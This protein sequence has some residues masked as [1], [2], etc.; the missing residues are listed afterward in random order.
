M[1][2]EL[3]ANCRTQA[4]AEYDDTTDPQEYLSC[5]ENA[6]LLHRYTNEIKCRVFVITFTH[7][8]QQWFNQLPVGAIGSFQEFRSL[9]L[10][11]FASSQKLQKMELSL[12]AIRQKNNES[13]KEYLQRFN[14]AALKVS[15]ATQGVKA[16]AFS[17]GLLDRD[18]FKSLAKKPISKFGALLARAAKYINMDDAQVAKKESRGEKRKETKEV[19][20]SK[21]PRTNFRDKKTPFQRVNAVYTPLTVPITQTLMAVERNDWGLKVGSRDRAE[22][23][24]PPRKGVIRMIVG[25]P[26][27][28]D[29]H[30][31]RKAEVR[32]AHEVTIKEVLDV[33]AIEDTPL[34]Q[35]GRAERSGP[36]N[37]HNDTL[38][39]TTMLSNY[40]GPQEGVS[41]RFYPL[42]RIDQLANCTSNCELLSMMD[43]S[44]GYYQIMLAL[45]DSKK[46]EMLKCM[47]ALSLVKSKE[48][49]DHVA[50]LEETFSV[51]RKYKLKLNPEKYAFGVWGCHCLGFMV[52]QRGIEANPLKIKPIL[53]MK[54]PTNTNEVQ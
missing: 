47:W 26:V 36:K 13:L 28:I 46:G 29:S 52:T 49:Q 18:F 20:P 22:P 4:I 24:G 9:F 2:D 10:H 11:Q 32:K 15:F 35:F 50:D 40:E 21:K 14:I 1:A 5:F 53:D 33:E 17:Q 8:A 3:F 37:S 6:A 23:S 44:Q 38:V 34:I 31:V 27:G 19:T 25:D 51:L 30:H 42:P 7:V 16:S 43:A 45:E 48:T 12:F 39:I 54:A 41:Q